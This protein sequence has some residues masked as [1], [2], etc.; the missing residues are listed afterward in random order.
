MQMMTR[1][2][3]VRLLG[4]GVAGMWLAGSQTVLDLSL[5]PSALAKPVSTPRLAPGAPMSLERI[6]LIDTFKEKS[7]GL[8]KQYEARVYKSDLTTRLEVFGCEEA[9][10][11]LGIIVNDVC[12]ERVPRTSSGSCRHKG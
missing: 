5:T 4:A 7:A 12:A 2:K 11:V 6:A 10:G 1:R 9:L 8:E 3:A